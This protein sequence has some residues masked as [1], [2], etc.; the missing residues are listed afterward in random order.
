MNFLGL[1]GIILIP[2]VII[3][4]YFVIVLPFT[5]IYKKAGYSPWMAVLMIIPMVNVFMLYFLGFS[6]WPSLNRNRTNL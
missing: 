4:W 5:K 3:L 6:N 2:F 1:K